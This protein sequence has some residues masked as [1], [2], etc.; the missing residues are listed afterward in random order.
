MLNRCKECLFYLIRYRKTELSTCYVCEQKTLQWKQNVYGTFDM[1]CSNCG[2][3]VSVDL[4]TPCELDYALRQKNKIE[5]SPQKQLP[6]SKIILKMSRLFQM[7][8]VMMRKKLEQGYIVEIE[9]SKFSEIISFLNENSIEYSV[10]FVENITEKYPLY[11]EC[12]YPYSL[13]RGYEKN[14]DII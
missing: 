3:V 1:E 2:G 12:N 14:Y 10:D 13:V 11:K 6:N 4:N 8:S 5:L 7:N 9:N